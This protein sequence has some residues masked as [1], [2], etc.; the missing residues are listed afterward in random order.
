[1]TQRATV[2][3]DDRMPARG[4]QVYP[5]MVWIEGGTFRMGSDRHYP[6]EAP[7]HQRARRRLL[8]RSHAGHQSG[9]PRFVK[10]T[11]SHVCRDPARPAGLSG[12][13]AGDAHPARW[14]SARRAGGPAELRSG[15]R[16]GSART[17]A[18]R[19]ARAARS[20]AWT[21]IRSC[22][23]RTRT[24][25][26]TPGGRARSCRPKPSGSSRRAAGSTAPS[27]PG[28]T[29]SRPA[30]GRWR[31]PGRAASRREQCARR[32]RAH[33]AGRG[34]P[35]E[36]LRPPR[37]DRQRL[38][39]DDRLV[40]PRSTG[41]CVKA[42]CI[43]G[44]PR[45]GQ[46]DRATTPASRRSGS[47]ARSQGRLAPVRAELLPPLSPGRAPR[48]AG[49]HVDLP[50][51][52]P[53]RRAEG[54]GSMMAPTLEEPVE[55]EWR[56]GGSTP[57]HCA[58]RAGGPL[59]LPQPPRSGQRQRRVRGTAAATRYRRRTRLRVSSELREP[60]TQL[61]EGRR[62]RGRRTGGSPYRACRSGV[63]HARA[64]ER[65]CAHRGADCRRAK[66]A[67]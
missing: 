23:S 22:T 38:G 46:E 30:A 10:A 20:A 21:T 26:P 51:R 29:S 15:G 36:R 62:P 9:V 44:N 64:S 60:Q 16:S 56:P 31:T 61:K 47:R 34:V 52:L 57:R 18:I 50:R 41:R 53:L 37:H 45:G 54:T 2:A 13:A 8:D 7:A 35:A 58:F 27:S 48:P 66:E 40:Q 28:A 63:S 39:V 49:R 1:M 14:C 19:T 55:N 59:R 25:R 11:D 5:E 43:P 12:R 17:G 33:V 32:L 3:S 4:A 67:P 65:P 42:C 6:E 24:P